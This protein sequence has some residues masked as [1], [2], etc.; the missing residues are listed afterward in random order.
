MVTVQGMSTHFIKLAGNQFDT[1]NPI[2]L[3]L[4]FNIRTVSSLPLFKYD[5]SRFSVLAYSAGDNFI[6]SLCFRFQ[7]LHHSCSRQLFVLSTYSHFQD[8]GY[9]STLEGSKNNLEPLVAFQGT[10]RDL[11]KKGRSNPLWGSSFDFSWQLSLRGISY[12]LAT[13]E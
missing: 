3:W 4:E 10:V 12:F 11:L 6:G 2:Y 5:P 9:S 1:L 7:L 13:V 8:G